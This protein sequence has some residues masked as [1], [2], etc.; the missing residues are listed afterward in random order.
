VA[1]LLGGPPMERVDGETGHGQDAVVREVPFAALGREERVAVEVLRAG[2]LLAE[3][4]PGRRPGAPPAPRRE[5]R[6]RRAG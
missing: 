3:P 4:R 6:P 2:G 5:T 1:A